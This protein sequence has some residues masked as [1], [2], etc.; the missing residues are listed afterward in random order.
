MQWA[1]RKELQV[2]VRCNETKPF[3]FGSLGNF[4]EDAVAIVNRKSQGSDC[5][6]R[7]DLIWC[8]ENSSKAIIRGDEGGVDILVLNGNKNNH[9]HGKKKILLETTSDKNDTS[10]RVERVE[11]RTTYRYA[12]QWCDQTIKVF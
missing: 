2:L 4:E 9:C 7:S 10:G 6:E 5:V 8:N 12:S 3:V 11:S 1:K